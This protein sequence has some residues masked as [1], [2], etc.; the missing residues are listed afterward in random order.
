MLIYSHTI[1]MTC[2]EIRHM[3]DDG[4]IDGDSEFCK[5]L[6]SLGR[7][8][9]S[10]LIAVFESS[11]EGKNFNPLTFDRKFFLQGASS[12]IEE[13]RDEIENTGKDAD[14]NS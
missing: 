9:D 1:S 3:I 11:Y 2:R 13:R 12:I 7:K 4:D 10:E 6:R 8:G 14:P 5:Q